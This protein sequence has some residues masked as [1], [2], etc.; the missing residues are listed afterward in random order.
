[1]GLERVGYGPAAALLL[2]VPH[3]HSFIFAFYCDPVT[4]LDTSP[5]GQQPAVHAGGVEEVEAG[6]SPHHVPRQ[7]VR[8][9]DHAVGAGL[10][11][12]PALARGS[13]S[14]HG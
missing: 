13:D 3:L 10:L 11:H 2:Y 14:D 7:E 6:E 9:A 4:W 12:T 1:M 5:V 8:Q